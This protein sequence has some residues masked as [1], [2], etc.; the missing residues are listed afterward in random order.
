[1][2]DT[3]DRSMANLAKYGNTMVQ[4]MIPITQ[5]TLSGYNEHP[6]IRR[7]YIRLTCMAQVKSNSRI[8]HSLYSS[9]H[10]V[11]PSRPLMA[12]LDNITSRAGK[13]RNRPLFLNQ[14]LP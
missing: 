9:G 14:P 13:C 5:Y 10:P 3:N 4:W 8:R 11:D 1:M 2:H 12:R 7:T 6:S